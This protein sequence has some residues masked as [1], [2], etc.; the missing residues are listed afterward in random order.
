[1]EMN[2]NHIGFPD[3]STRSANCAGDPLL[4]T[5]EQRRPAFALLCIFCEAHTS[6]FERLDKR[7]A[8]ITM[9]HRRQ[10]GSTSTAPP[11][12]PPPPSTSTPPRGQQP[13]NQTFKPL[14]R[15]STSLYSPPAAAGPASTPTAGGKARYSLPS[16]SPAANGYGGP[17]TSSYFPSVGVSSPSAFP[18]M[19]QGNQPASFGYMGSTASDYPR[20]SYEQSTRYQS[21][22]YDLS[23]RFTG[24]STKDEILASV[25]S[26]LDRFVRGLR[27]ASRLDRSWAMVRED[28]ELRNLI[29]RST[30]IN[31]VSLLLLSF[32]PIVL[33]PALSLSPD[34]QSKARNVGMWYNMLLSW[35][36]FVFCFWINVSARVPPAP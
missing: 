27:D 25:R 32:S 3:A 24:D 4:P 14:R 29:L 6:S 34:A 30:L 22:L 36:V 21:G 12:P 20:A 26:A 33:S 17:G 19:N 31:L 28:T 18:S 1:M 11:P 8:S 23:E 16:S 13:S 15:Q 10:T 9:L 7:K 5:L 2:R 35:P